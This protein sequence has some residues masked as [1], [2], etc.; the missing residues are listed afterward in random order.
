MN[1]AADM[2]AATFQMM[3]LALGSELTDLFPGRFLT[4]GV[5]W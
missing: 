2:I 5:T 4:V 3:F 1:K